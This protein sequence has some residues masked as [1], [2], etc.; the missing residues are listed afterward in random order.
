[1]K[2]ILKSTFFAVLAVTGINWIGGP[3]ARI[4]N[5]QQP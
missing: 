5:G 3:V 2:T 1:M 4:M